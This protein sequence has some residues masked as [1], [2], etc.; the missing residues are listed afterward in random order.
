[1]LRRPFVE[2]S[3]LHVTDPTATLG[4]VDVSINPDTL[5]ALDRWLVY[6]DQSVLWEYVVPENMMIA[7]NQLQLTCTT[8]ALWDKHVLFNGPE[9]AT[10]LGTAIYKVDGVAI[11]E[12][13]LMSRGSAAERGLQSVGYGGPC[14]T[15]WNPRSRMI[16]FPGG[17]SLDAGQVLTVEWTTRT[18]FTDDAGA[19]PPSIIRT[20]LQASATVSGEYVHAGNVFRPL[21]PA[22]SQ[23]VFSYTVPA[24]GI[25]ARMWTITA[26]RIHNLFVARCE[27]RVNDVQVTVFGHIRGTMMRVFPF[28]SIPLG[29]LEFPAGT[30]F[31]LLGSTWSDHGGK[32]QVNLVGSQRSVSGLSRGR[33]SR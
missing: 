30:R 28:L 31:T 13:K 25:R 6:E 27:L 16:I 23:V 26:R 32:I 33:R 12:Q 22:A 9:T 14:S 15:D 8:D 19:A 17:I 18:D 5:N 1:M 3:V 4:V 7:V 21:T 10:I 2:H 20:D 29:G 24:G 11:W